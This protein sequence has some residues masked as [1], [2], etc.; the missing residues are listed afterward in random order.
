VSRAPVAKSP[1]QRPRLPRVKLLGVA[2]PQHLQHQLRFEDALEVTP[3]QRLDALGPVLAQQRV[4]RRAERARKVEE[5]RQRK[6]KIVTEAEKLGQGRDW[7][8][9]ANRLRDLLEEWKALPRLD[10]PTDDALWHRFSTA[11]TT[12]TRARKSHFSELDDKRGTS[13][14]LK[15]RL[16][17]DAEEL[18]TS[19]E[20]GPTA[21]RYRDL[22]SSWKEAGPAA[23]A[24]DD[25]LWKRFR[26]AQDEFFGARDAA[27]AAM[28]AEF[29]ANAVTKDALLV[30][31]EALLPVTDLGRAKK[32][33]RDISERWDA[34]GKV[35]RNRMKDLDA[36]IRK[37]ETAIRGVE[38]AKWTKTDP[39]KSARA[40]DMI[41]KLEKTIADIETDL[42]AARERGDAKRVKQQEENLT[43]RVAFLEM[44]KRT[45]ADFG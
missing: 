5:S 19:T 34:A 3:Q 41:S 15:E 37:V 38:D 13:K 33:F 16:I 39:E 17:K 4:V 10:R 44:A 32:A 12:Y 1:L 40:D 26:G 7:R 24:E 36:R 6:E 14:A 42:A 2:H 21:G 18:A 11:R 9:G 22:M 25:A 8:N 20:W 29:T 45:A 27:M 28:D 23:K 35:P 43:S 30:E 31:A